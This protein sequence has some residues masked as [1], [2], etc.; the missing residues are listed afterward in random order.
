MLI[1]KGELFCVG[2]MFFAI[3]ISVILLSLSASSIL[4]I[5]VDPTFVDAGVLESDNVYVF[6]FEI[7]NRF[8]FSVPLDISFELTDTSKYLE[9]N[10]L[11]FPSNTVVDIDGTSVFFSVV[12]IGVKNISEGDHL[13]VFRPLPVP[14]DEAELNST[15]NITV[16]SYIVPTVAVAIN[17]SVY[18][19]PSLSPTVPSGYGSSS[20]TSLPT[21]SLPPEETEPIID[22]KEITITAPWF[23]RV[24][25][26]NDTILVKL[27]NTGTFN[28]TSLSIKTMITPSFGIDYEENI[29]SLSSGE[30]KTIVFNISDF[31]STYHFLSIVISDGEDE[32]EK[33]IIL[34]VPEVPR[35]Q[36]YS[37]MDCIEFEPRNATVKKGEET[38]INLTVRNICDIT[39]HNMNVVISGFDYLKH[40]DF[41]K[42]DSSLYLEMVQIPTGEDETYT[43]LFLY[44]EGETVSHFHVYLK[45]GYRNIFVGIAAIIILL[46][47]HRYRRQ[48]RDYKTILLKCKDILVNHALFKKLFKYGKHMKIRHPAQRKNIKK[49][50]VQL[51]K[52]YKT[53]KVK[54]KRNMSVFRFNDNMRSEVKK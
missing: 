4:A 36:V 10:I 1:H 49:R 24:A 16:A 28:F 9:N 13:L 15:H 53:F 7:T 54:E 39:L 43:V 46:L 3:I 31:S 44:D 52:V 45:E 32:W 34:F 50:D 41:I 21:Q 37:D 25:Q 30:E 17:F 35:E 48:I 27:T 33:N 26:E 20:Y 5:S 22:I 29:G 8:P 11:F 2:Q 6:P 51:K 23:F 47:I 14:V 38:R 12:I 42:P 18:H 19:P 40:I